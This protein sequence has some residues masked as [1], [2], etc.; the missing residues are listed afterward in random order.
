[1]LLLLGILFSVFRKQSDRKERV[2][3]DA[4]A[5]RNN[6]DRREE[7]IGTKVRSVCSWTFTLRRNAQLNEGC[8]HHGHCIVWT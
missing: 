1:M 7:M 6:P 5:I 3:G 8:T 2:P 4:L